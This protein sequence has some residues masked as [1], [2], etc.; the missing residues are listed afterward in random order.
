MCRKMIGRRSGGRRR[1]DRRLGRL[2][3]RH[4]EGPQTPGPGP[5]GPTPSRGF[6]P[7]PGAVT[8]CS[9]RRGVPPSLAT[10]PPSPL[11]PGPGPGHVVAGLLVVLHMGPV[12]LGPR[13][14]PP[15]PGGGAGPGPPLTPPPT[16]QRPS[17]G[18][19]RCSGGRQGT[20]LGTQGECPTPRG[21]AGGDAARTGGTARGLNPRN[22]PPFIRPAPLPP[23]LHVS[24]LPP[25]P[26]WH[27]KSFP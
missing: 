2:G 19:I 15:A 23:P 20:T 18:G 24:P 11:A 12:A 7:I 6:R 14:R 9:G 8:G 13:R 3:G 21:V 25:A 10:N 4:H 27:R 5:P 1:R 26:R 16:S 22:P 17:L